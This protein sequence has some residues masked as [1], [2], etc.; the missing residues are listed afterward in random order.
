MIWQK[1]QKSTITSHL[2]QIYITTLIENLLEFRMRPYRLPGSFL[3]KREES[4]D[5]AYDVGFSV[6]SF[7]AH[8][9]ALWRSLQL[10]PSKFHICD[11]FNNMFNNIAFF[12]M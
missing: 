6:N 10:N 1:S 9:H 2:S 8:I 4:E 3:S 7:P 11:M 12:V 5:P